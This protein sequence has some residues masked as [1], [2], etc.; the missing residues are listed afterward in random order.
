[1]EYNDAFPFAT[2][3]SEYA[4]HWAG[5]VRSLEDRRAVIDRRPDHEDPQIHAVTKGNDLA[6]IDGELGKARIHAAAAHSG[7]VF[8]DPADLK[9]GCDRTHQRWVAEAHKRGALVNQSNYEPSLHA[10]K[11]NDIT[12]QRGSGAVQF[13]A[14]GSR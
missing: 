9:L 8:H 1:M 10:S 12:V 3:M 2:N 7:V 6:A 14:P 5:K 4:G 13:G 11:G